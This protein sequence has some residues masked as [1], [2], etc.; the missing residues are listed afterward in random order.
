[1]EAPKPEPFMVKGTPTK[2][3]PSMSPPIHE[4]KAVT[5]NKEGS[6]SHGLTVPKA[7]QKLAPVSNSS[8]RGTEPPR[9]E[10]AAAKISN[11]LPTPVKSGGSSGLNVPKPEGV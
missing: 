11:K 1:M 8:G 2:R 9:V 3:T 10:I 5:P 6:R 7:G 4:S